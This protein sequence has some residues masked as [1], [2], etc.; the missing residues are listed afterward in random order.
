MTKAI[1]AHFRVAIVGSGFSGLGM[2]IKL[3]EQGEQDFV[4]FE[5]EGGVGGTWRV[6]HYPGCACDIP[7][8]LYSFSF[9]N[10]PDWSRLYPP[11]AEIKQ[12]L[13]GCADKYQIRPH[14][15]L[16]C[17]IESAR[18][19]DEYQLWELQDE[20]GNAYTANVV[21]GAIGGLS[22][23]SYPEIPGLDDF[24]GKAFHSQDWDHSYDLKGKRVA[25]IGTGAS[26]IQFV[27]EVQKLAGKLY[28]FQRT[29]PWIMPKPDRAMR[30]AEKTLFRRLEKAQVAFR[31]ALYWMHESRFIAFAVN[32]RLMLVAK[33]MALHHLR[34]QVKDKTLRQQLTPNYTV[35]CKRI[36]LSDNYYPAVSQPNVDVISDGIDRVEEHA[37][38]TKDGV[39]HEVDAIIFGTGFKATDPIP[40]G[41]I[42]GRDGLDIVD[43]WE[44]GAEAYKGTTITGFPNLFFIMGPNTGLGHNSMVYMIESQ[45]QYI[46]DA[47]KYMNN[48]QA[49]TVEV[50]QEAQQ[51]FNAKLQSKL[52]GSVWNDGG[53]QSWYLDPKTGK[54][55]TLW[56]GFTWQFRR[57]TREFDAVAYSVGRGN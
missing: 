6:N 46:T 33:R 22:T 26:A 3:K 30:W 54:N 20:H 25:V 37:V 9:E 48:N 43:N 45:I 15:R 13:E 5:K 2:A 56:P 38:V 4:V 19:N 17:A 51:A 27:P 1:T 50:K 47:L 18:W 10:N 57:Q 42:F 40:K 24:K 31:N 49:K 29:P 52:T 16:N 8:H 32:P 44:Q 21:V 7:S 34:S 14:L 35:G 39:R 55:V 41:V 11:Q 23:P 36:L 53:C 12:Y 28:L